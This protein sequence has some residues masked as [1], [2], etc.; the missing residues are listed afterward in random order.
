LEG[1]LESEVA[2]H[3]YSHKLKQL[4]KGNPKMTM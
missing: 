1:Y 2:M 3:G 4:V